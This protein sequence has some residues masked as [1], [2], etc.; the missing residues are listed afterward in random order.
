MMKWFD[1]M[2]LVFSG[3]R[4]YFICTYEHINTRTQIHT[5]YFGS[6]HC[7][8]NNYYKSS[9]FVTS[10]A[11][12]TIISHAT[13]CVCDLELTMKF[14]STFIVFIVPKESTTTT[15]I[16]QIYVQMWKL[17]RFRYCREAYFEKS[18][19]MSLFH[20]GISFVCKKVHKANNIIFVAVM[21]NE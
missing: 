12:S 19:K 13:M 4:V 7:S 11:H 3:V 1:V 9:L 20:H 10:G 5:Q 18:T 15:T 8:W 2:V 16:V 6:K 14:L 21:W 17:F